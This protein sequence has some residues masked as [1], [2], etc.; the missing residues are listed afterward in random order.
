MEA[1]I[2]K[3]LMKGR[4]MIQELR[5]GRIYRVCWGLLGVAGGG[6]GAEQGVAL[7]DGLRARREA[8]IR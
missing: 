4:G 8:P 3:V 2:S 1:G 5:A 7:G 6:G